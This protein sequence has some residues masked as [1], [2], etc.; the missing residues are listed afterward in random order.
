MNTVKVCANTRLKVCA[1]TPQENLLLRN[2][3]GWPPQYSSQ[4][5]YMA[6]YALGISDLPEDEMVQVFRSNKSAV[7]FALQSYHAVQ[8][9]NAAK[10][11]WR[12]QRLKI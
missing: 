7:M 4:E 12:I 1:S 2:K 9:K 10:L 8:D 11:I 5:L 6:L 3:I